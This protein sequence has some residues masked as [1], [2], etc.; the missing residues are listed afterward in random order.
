MRGSTSG[1]RRD[2][3]IQP[4]LLGVFDRVELVAG[5]LRVAATSL[6]PFL[7]A[8]ERRGEN[9]SARI[10]ARATGLRSAGVDRDGQR[11]RRLDHP[12]RRQTEVFP[13]AVA[14]QLYA[15]R[16]PVGEAGGDRERGEAEQV[17]GHQQAVAAE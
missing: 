1:E 3:T 11:A 2:P 6:G 12:A 7:L 17:D 16:K 8:E 15:L 14:D 5:R 9:P 4:N 13:V 10:G